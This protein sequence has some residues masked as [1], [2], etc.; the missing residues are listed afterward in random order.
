MKFENSVKLAEFTRNIF[1]SP[2]F[3]AL[4]PAIQLAL[5]SRSAPAE[6]GLV[7]TAWKVDRE[8]AVNAG[9]SPEPSPS[10]VRAAAALASSTR[11]RPK[12]VKSVRA[13]VPVPVK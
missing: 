3:A 13:A 1:R 11:D 12:P 10:V 5:G 8:S 2:E 6:A 7:P 4:R 9:E